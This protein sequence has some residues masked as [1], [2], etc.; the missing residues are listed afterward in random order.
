MRR[1]REERG[2]DVRPPTEEL[3]AAAQRV[4]LDT[5]AW[6]PA[7]LLVDGVAADAIEIS[8]DGWWLVLHVGVEEV[9]DVYVYGPPHA[10]PEPLA[11]QRIRD[12]DYPES[13]PEH[14]SAA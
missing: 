3:W 4:A 12:K 11:L 13:D 2:G 8:D 10:R 7:E 9:A 6:R 14:Q 1:S 5:A